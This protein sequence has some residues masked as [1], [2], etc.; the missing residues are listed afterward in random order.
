[1][2]HKEKFPPCF[3]IEIEA[4][5]KRLKVVAIKNTDRLKRF[6]ETSSSLTFKMSK[7]VQK[8]M[9]QPIVSFFAFL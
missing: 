9:V 2:H 1:M 7:K 3:P 5:G 6:I 8:V 4:V